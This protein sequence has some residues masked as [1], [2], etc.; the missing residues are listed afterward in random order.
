V[1]HVIRIAKRKYWREIDIW[2]MIRKMRG[3]Q[4]Y[5]SIPA[6]TNKDKLAVTDEKKQNYN[7]KHSWR[8]IV[9]TICLGK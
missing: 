4:R 5:N 3:I 8:C 1:K 6:L 2:G 9:M 7:Q